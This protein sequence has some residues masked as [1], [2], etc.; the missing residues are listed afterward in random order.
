[1]S[2]I[3]DALRRATN[4]NNKREA[5][6]LPAMQPTYKT[7]R[8]GGPGFSIFVVC[9]LLA[10]GVTLGAWFYYKRGIGAAGA[11]PA[12]KPTLT[13]NNNP[14]ARAS[15]TLGAVGSLNKEGESA[16]ENMQAGAPDAGVN[17]TPAIGTPPPTA[18]APSGGPKLQGIF[19]SAN[20]ASAIINGKT[21]KVGDEVDGLKVVAIT[22]QAVRVEIAGQ[23]RELRM[24]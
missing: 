3:N 7:V 23:A 13:T 4:E 20:N 11:K 21:V 6:E 9:F 22:Q 10:A 18:V 15:Q 8:T 1:M 12:A 5:N 16:A 2:L 24:K 14:L 19:Y 17:P